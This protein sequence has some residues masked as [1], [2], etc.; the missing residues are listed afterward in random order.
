M[1]PSFNPRDFDGDTSY[2]IMFGP[3]ICGND[4]KVHAILNYKEKNHLI[5]SNIA[6]GSDQLTHLYTFIIFPNQTYSILVD[7][8]EEASGSIFDSWDLLPPLEIKD[9]KAKKPIDWI[10]EKTIEDPNDEKPSDWDSEPEF[11]ENITAM[12]PEDWDEE[13]DG[14]W[15]KPLLTNPKFKG[16][17]SPK[18]ILNPD[19]KGEWKHP[20]IANPEF[21]MDENIFAYTTGFVGFDLWYDG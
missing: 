12:K 13:E 8:V 7:Q 20:M 15:V 1:P 2:H 10:D 21:E 14:V 6:P 4:K 11:I 19:Y 18:Q 3:D 17:W 5:K 9:P 16:M